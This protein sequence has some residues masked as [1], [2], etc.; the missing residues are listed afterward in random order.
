MTWRSEPLLGVFMRPRLQPM[1]SNGSLAVSV[2]R[3]GRASK[4][5]IPREFN[6]PDRTVGPLGIHIVMVGDR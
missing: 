4:L 5:G 3:C 1:G 2:R 6:R